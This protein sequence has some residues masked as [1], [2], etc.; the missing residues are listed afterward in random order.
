MRIVGELQPGFEEKLRILTL[1]ILMHWPARFSDMAVS[2]LFLHV[3][4]L[5]GMDTSER[6][7]R[8][9]KK[10]DEAIIIHGNGRYDPYKQLSFRPKFEKYKHLSSGRILWFP[11]ANGS[12]QIAYLRN[13][14]VVALFQKHYHRKRNRCSHI[15][16]SRTCVQNIRFQTSEIM[17]LKCICVC[18]CVWRIEQALCMAFCSYG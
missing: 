17:C 15:C 1:R 18:A 13:H 5:I 11:V 12:V 9:E 6:F 14:S 3:G 8:P 2:T 7:A 16:I 10:W 4:I